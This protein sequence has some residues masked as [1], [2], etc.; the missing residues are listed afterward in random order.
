[1]NTSNIRTERVSDDEIK[2]VSC[3][4][5]D[6]DERGEV[7]IGSVGP[8]IAIGSIAPDFNLSCMDGIVHKLSDYRGS[9]VMLCFYRFTLCPVC[10]YNIGTLV[11]HYKKLAWASKLKVR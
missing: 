11:G 9:K 3:P 5:E 4:C 8:K 7:I 10:A 1:M 2:N 6:D